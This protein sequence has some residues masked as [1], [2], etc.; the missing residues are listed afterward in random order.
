[1]HWKYIFW[2]RSA[3]LSPGPCLHLSSTG[4]WSSIELW[5]LHLKIVHQDSSPANGHQDDMPCWWKART[6]Q[7]F[8]IINNSR[9]L[10]CFRVGS[11]PSAIPLYFL[12]NMTMWS[13]E[14][15]YH[16]TG[17]V[18]LH[19]RS[20]SNEFSWGYK[21]VDGVCIVRDLQCNWCQILDDGSASSMQ[22]RY[23]ISDIKFATAWV[24]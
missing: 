3:I 9:C 5:C 18:S 24:T 15:H 6:C 11:V 23:L 19:L 2:E 14:S 13:L 4:T 20:S 22:S 12:T 17:G 16:I 21:F 8:M 10:S 1:M 7:C